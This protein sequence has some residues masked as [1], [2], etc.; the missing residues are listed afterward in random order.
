MKYAFFVAGFV[1]AALL[2][3]VYILR[4][5]P[6]QPFAGGDD[7]PIVVAG[8]S[9]E[10]GSHNGFA[11]DPQ[12]PKK[13]DHQ[14]KGRNVTRIDV[15]YNDAT[16]GPGYQEFLVDKGGD[17]R[18]DIDYVP[19]DTP[20]PH[21]TVTFTTQNGGKEL[22]IT[23]CSGC[24]PIGGE[25]NSASTTIVHQPPDGTVG[26]ITVS[27]KFNPAPAPANAGPFSCVNGKCQ[28][29]LHYWCK[30]GGPHDSDCKN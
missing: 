26:Q 21:D 14:D 1:V 18:V 17:I 3:G 28:V 15:L 23:N 7:E 13:A 16:T 10:V 27:G 25:V 11:K 5:G 22:G 12:D 19:K 8:G 4:K 24:P 29:V 2:A 6:I 30:S 20:K 9:F